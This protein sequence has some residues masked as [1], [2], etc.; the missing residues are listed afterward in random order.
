MEKIVPI[1]NA[2]VT[3][4]DRYTKEESKENGIYLLDQAEGK[5]KIKQ[6]IISVGSTACK[7]LKVGDV[8]VISPRQYI[9]KEQ[10][11]KAFQLVDKKWKVHIML[12]GQ[13][14]SLKVKKFYSYMIQM[15]S[16]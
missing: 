9:R 12:N 3:T 6:T 5:I 13:L 14:K 4:A 8:V 10:K 1:Y 16:I 11:P 2:I 7:D 15:L